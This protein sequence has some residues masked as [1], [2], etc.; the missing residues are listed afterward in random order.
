MNLRWIRESHETLD[1]FE[2]FVERLPVNPPGF[3][4]EG[5]V[6]LD[7]IEIGN[8]YENDELVFEPRLRDNVGEVNR[9]KLTAEL[10]EELFDCD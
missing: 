7:Q 10:D 2:R 8:W 1:Y 6:V 3:R 5:D 9:F 4:A